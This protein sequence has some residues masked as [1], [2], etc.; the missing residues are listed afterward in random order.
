MTSTAFLSLTGTIT[1]MVA[2]LPSGGV[3]ILV[4]DTGRGIPARVGNKIFEPG[5]T[6]KKR[7]WGMGLA[8]VERIVTQ[9]HGGRVSIEDTSSHGTT[10]Q[11]LLPA[12]DEVATAVNKSTDIFPGEES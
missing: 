12:A 11:I 6:T 9:Y 8:L 5:F 2:D 7:G 10:F 4:S 3:K 1:L